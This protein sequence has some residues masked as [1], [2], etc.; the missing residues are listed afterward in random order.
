MYFIVRVQQEIGQ[1]PSTHGSA[2][3]GA[4]L[5]MV[6]VASALATVIS[7]PRVFHD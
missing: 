3:S 1:K 4:G 5:I 7:V 2:G 6:L